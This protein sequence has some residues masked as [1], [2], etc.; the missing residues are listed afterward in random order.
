[1]VSIIIVNY[2]TAKLT[3]N[4]IS[5][6]Y[7]QVRCVEFEIIVVDNASG[8]RSAFIIQDQYPD[9]IVIQ[10][11]VNLGFGRANNLGVQY[12]QGE[13]LFLLNSDTILKNDPFSYFLSYLQEHRDEKIGVL[14]AFLISSNGE[15]SK[16]GGR[17]YTIKK[18]LKLALK[19]YCPIFKSVEVDIDKN[20]LEVDYVIGADMFL[21]KKIFEE[22]KGFD[23]RIFMYF[24]DVELC[25]RIHDKGYS[26]FL[27]KGPEII[28]LVSASSTSQFSRIYNTASLIYCLKKTYVGWKVFF[29]QLFYFILKFPILF[30]DYKKRSDNWTYLKTIWCYKKYL[31]Q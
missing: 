1:M 27:L 4:C 2:K 9:V 30:I 23:D 15:Y 20:I 14:G 5:S 17:F 8:D 18:Y 3:C 31:L 28:H 29:F 10:S 22:L 16:S 7:K 24:E 19:S 11:S 25:K 12:A 6:I 26:S 21:K 13:Y